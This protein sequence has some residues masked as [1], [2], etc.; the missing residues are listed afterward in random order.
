[1]FSPPKNS[2]KA[3]VNGKKATKKTKKFDTTW[4]NRKGAPETIALI[5]AGRIGIPSSIKDI[6]TPKLVIRS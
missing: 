3:L 2:C 4:I 5:K 6:A 1:M